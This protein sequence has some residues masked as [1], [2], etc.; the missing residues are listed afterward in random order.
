[1]TPPLRAPAARQTELLNQIVRAGFMSVGDLAAA[2][3][4]SE[5]TVRRDLAALEKEGAVRRTHGGALGLGHGE[6][7]VFDALE[8]SFAARRRRNA[9]A[10]SARSFTAARSG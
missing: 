1:M 3:G 5:I 8:P 10:K 6:A 2:T 7:D 9:K 4:V